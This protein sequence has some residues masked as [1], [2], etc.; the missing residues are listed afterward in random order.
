MRLH[1]CSASAPCSNVLYAISLQGKRAPEY[2]G[3]PSTRFRAIRFPP[4][5]SSLLAREDPLRVRK[6]GEQMS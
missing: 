6:L 4:L 2:Q 3:L 5:H 1:P